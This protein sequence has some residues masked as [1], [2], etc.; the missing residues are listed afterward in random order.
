MAKHYTV[1]TDYTV[2]K[3]ILHKKGQLDQELQVYQMKHSSWAYVFIKLWAGITE[4]LRFET[5]LVDFWFP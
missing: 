5:L 2:F 3:I 1:F 4:I